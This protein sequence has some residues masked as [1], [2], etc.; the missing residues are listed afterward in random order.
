MDAGRWVAWRA[1]FIRGRA[2]VSLIQFDDL[3]H[4]GST[5]RQD[6]IVAAA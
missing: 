1:G 4:P 3:T 2:A 6:A 5:N